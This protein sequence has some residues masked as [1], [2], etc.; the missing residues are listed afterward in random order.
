MEKVHCVQSKLVIATLLMA[1][2]LATIPTTA[3]AQEAGTTQIFI[4][5]SFLDFKPTGQEIACAGS[6]P[7][8]VEAF[9][10]EKD[11]LSGFHS[12][13]TYWLTGRLGI[14]GEFSGHYN[15][16]FPLPPN[17]SGLTQMDFE[18][19]Q[20]LVGPRIKML[21]RGR[22][23]SSFRAVFGA[24]IGTTFPAFADVNDPLIG[25]PAIGPLFR[26]A[27]ETVFAM[28][29]GVSFDVSVN[30]TVAIRVIQPNLNITNYAGEYQKN[31][32]FSS[33]LIFS[34]GG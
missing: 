33:G 25:D 27:D 9:E 17:A 14:M 8:E 6:C 7:P 23:S 16:E 12:S 31:F 20:F 2:G 4:G 21:Q 22:L 34:L 15:G 29:I 26:A 19:V 5:Y 11:K 18:Q 32:R 10:I 28:D 1:V 3:T 13:L 30:D 24:S